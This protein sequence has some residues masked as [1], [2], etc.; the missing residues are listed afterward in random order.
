VKSI[1]ALVSVWL[2]SS[3]AW[4]GIIDASVVLRLPDGRTCGGTCIDSTGASVVASAAHCADNQVTGGLTLNGVRSVD[5]IMP[6][7]VPDNGHA[8]QDK[9]FA[10]F[11]FPAG[12]CRSTVAMDRTIQEVGARLTVVKKNGGPVT[13]IVQRYVGGIYIETTNS[14]GMSPG[15]SGS[16]VFSNSGAFLGA[17]RGCAAVGCGFFNV[18][19]GNGASD[20]V[21]MAAMKRGYLAWE[22]NLPNSSVP[23]SASTLSARKLYSC[24]ATCRV[25]YGG[26][27][28]DTKDYTT[29]ASYI[30]ASSLVEAQSL[31]Q[32][33]VAENCAEYCRFSRDAV[34]CRITTQSFCS[35]M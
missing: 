12:T 6:S 11:V 5:A 21:I 23:S 22:M 28:E 35:Q 26:Q 30:S 17:L 10:L 4:A 1:F 18:S 34:S 8:P 31:G 29:R 27:F 14:S 13:E 16:G 7:F 2:V 3:T 24:D 9:D 20:A 19:R 25:T 32:A 33:T 15:D